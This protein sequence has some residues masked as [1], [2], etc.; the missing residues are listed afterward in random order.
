[1]KLYAIDLS[2]RQCR[3]KIIHSGTYIVLHGKDFTIMHLSVEPS[4][5]FSSDDI[6]NKYF[7]PFLG[8]FQL[9]IATI[10]KFSRTL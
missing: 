4:S 1:M 10:V 8:V 3:Y 7:T 6:I 2:S 9:M 5:S